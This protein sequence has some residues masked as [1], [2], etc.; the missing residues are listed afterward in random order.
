MSIAIVILN[1]NGEQDTLKCLYSLEKSSFSSYEVIAVDNGSTDNSAAS[2]HAKF[3]HIT[4]LTLS[5]NLGYAGGNNKG[6]EYALQKGH[7]FILLLNNDTTVD[8]LFL[9]HLFQAT[10][11]H[12][13]VGIFGAKPLLMS[14]PS[15]IDHL[16]GKWNPFKGR[17]DLVGQNASADFS[18]S[19]ELDYVCGCSILIR[20][21]VFE[22][23]GLL[24]PAYF[25]FWE[26][27]D[28]CK[29]AK[30]AGFDIKVCER[31]ILFHKVSAS[32]V[33]G[34]AHKIYFWWRNRF[35]W[36]QRNCSRQE[37]RSLLWKVLLPEMWQLYK[38]WT[39]KS[40]EIFLLKLSFRTKNLSKK[41]LKIKE[42][43][44]ALQGCHDFFR[45]RFGN[46]PAWIFE[47]PKRQSEF[48]G[49]TLK[50]RCD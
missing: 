39:I 31:A 33:G 48:C 2:I 7:S 10:Q 44:A 34:S 22:K 6:I 17:F 49:S 5:E 9:T 11:E 13:R 30:K 38:L 25:L 14:N 16:G 8:P 21:E 35:L 23:I 45:K 15:L 43:S 3:P 37:Y 26:E 50:E 28:F 36:I 29:Q 32:F 46:G 18:F 47:R 12:P 1:W 40:L 4:L 20:R 27:A 42:Y 24:E 41:E 19:G